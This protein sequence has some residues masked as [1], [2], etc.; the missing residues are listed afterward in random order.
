MK[1][2]TAAELCKQRGVD[3]GV[4]EKLSMQVVPKWAV[5]WM[6]QQP[7]AEPQRDSKGT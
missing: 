6:E 4:A 5:S 7:G 1:E 2:L 3:E